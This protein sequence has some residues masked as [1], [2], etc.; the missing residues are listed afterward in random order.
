M[1]LHNENLKLF[2]A[3]LNS[4]QYNVQVRSLVF[5]LNRPDTEE[6][7]TTNSVLQPYVTHILIGFMRLTLEYCV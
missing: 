4:A 3:N 2:K 7:R 1:S 6:A 5:Q